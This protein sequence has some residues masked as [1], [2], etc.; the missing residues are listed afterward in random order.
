MMTIRTV[1]AAIAFFSFAPGAGFGQ[2]TGLF[3]NIDAE[4]AIEGTVREVIR[5]PLYQD[6]QPFIQVVLEDDAQERTLVEVCPAWYAD[7]DFRVGDRLSVVGSLSGAEGAPKSMIARIVEFEDRTLVL[8]DK[9]GFPN[10]RGGT[11]A[12]Q[13]RRRGRGFV[14]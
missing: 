9:R 11:R 12:K 5:T 8:R 7:I 4:A 13:G 6:R 10:W 14:P 3:Y 2:Q 1:L